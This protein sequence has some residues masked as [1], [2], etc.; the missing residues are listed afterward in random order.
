MDEDYDF[1]IYK[2][3]NETNNQGVKDLKNQVICFKIGLHHEKKK[4]RKKKKKNCTKFY[5]IE[6]S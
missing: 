2:R 3:G 6:M 4:N 1:L 5:F